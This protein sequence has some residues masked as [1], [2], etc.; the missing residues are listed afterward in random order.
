M[1]MDGV[2]RR[3]ARSGVD[4]QPALCHLEDG[5]EVTIT[6]AVD[7]YRSDDGEW[8]L[9]AARRDRSFRRQLAPAVVLDRSGGV[10]L[11]LRM[12]GIRSRAGRG[13]RRHVHEPWT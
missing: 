9:G 10:G 4:R 8:K 6:W 12:V 11:T 5:E 2:E 1:N 3:V 13:L 7:C